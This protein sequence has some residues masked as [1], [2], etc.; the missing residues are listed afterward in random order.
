MIRRTFIFAA[1]LSWASL[2]WGDGWQRLVILHTNDIHGHLPAEEAWWINPNFPP[3][4]GNA[5]GAASVIKEERAQASSNGWGLLLLEG[6]DIFQGTPTGEFSKGMA[7]I[8]YMNAM[9]YDAMVVGNHDFDKGQVVLQDLIQRARFP[10]LCANIVDSATGTI[11]DYFKPYV[12]VERAGLRIGIFGLGLPSLRGVVKPED[13]KGLDIRPVVQTARWTVDTLRA[14]GADL[15]IGLD[16]IGY[17]GDKVLADSVPGIDVIV[18]AHSHSGLRQAYEDPANHTIIVQTFGN[19]STI[20][21]LELNIDP[22]TKQIVGYRS[23]LRELFT[24][25][26][27]KDT[28]TAAAVKRWTDQAEAGFDSVIGYSSSD[29]A[30]VG[31]GKESALG[32]LIADAI[33]E[34]SGADFAFQ[35]SGGIRADIRKGEVTFRDLYQVDPFGNTIV[36][37][38]LTGPQVMRLLET[39]VL[40]FHGIFQVSG[41]KMVYDNRKPIWSRVT[42][43]T[44]DGKS[45][46]LD[47]TYKIATNDFLAAGGGYYKIFQ[48]GANRD[49]T[50]KQVRQAMVDYFRKHSPLDVRIEGRIKEIGGGRAS[51]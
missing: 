40:G 22:G 30:R 47:K 3:P 18:G 43:A 26:V 32:D 46:D 17:Y 36:T 41:L 10:V 27:P 14:Q 21:R 39:S 35:N 7:V 25:D 4:I 31:G 33:R 28:A 48:E 6:G 50:Y 2:G 44:V 29:L 1:V 15:V 20:G 42:E 9:G 5:P 23:E 51:R 16:H 12:I 8:D 45:L 19:L 38:D 49:D 34:A 11:P 13:L 24:E 37:M